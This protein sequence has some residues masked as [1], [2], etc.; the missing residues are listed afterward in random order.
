MQGCGYSTAAARPAASTWPARVPDR[1]TPRPCRHRPVRDSHRL[2]PARRAPRRTCRRCRSRT[3]RPQV[4]GAAQH[5]GGWVPLVLPP[6]LLAGLRPG[7]L[8][9]LHRRLGPDRAQHAEQLPRLAAAVRPARW[10]PGAHRG[11]DRAPGDDRSGHP[12]TGQHARLRRLAVRVHHLQRA[13]RCLD[14]A[15]RPWRLRASPRPTTRPTARRRRPSSPRFSAGVHH[16]QPTRP[17]SSSRSTTPATSSRCRRCRCS[18]APNTDPVVGAA[19]DIACDPNQIAF[20]DGQGTDTDCR[21]IAHR[22]PARGRRRGA[23]ARRQPVRL[24]RHA[25]LRRSPTTRRGAQLKSIT[26]PVPGD[27]DYAT[28][29]GTDCP[30]VAGA[31][32]YQYFGA[33]AGDPSKGYYSYNLGQWHVVALNTAP[34][35]NDADLLRRRLG[36][37]PVAQAGPRGEHV[38]LH[39]RLLP[40]P[41][42][43]LDR[44]RRRRRPISRSGRTSTTA[45]S[46]WCSTVTRTGTSGSRR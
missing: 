40:E 16:Q 20:N 45:A 2:R 44:R 12:G 5:G 36:A 25:G 13:R 3:C 31:G 10:R 34:C 18:V 26:H 6:G 39:A 23:A 15:T 33:A 17:S 30:T 29:G 32:Y 41:A 4:N 42:V 46:T 38:V 28:S 11:G 21:A 7:Q 37:G 43:R 24:R 35:G 22:R 1:S 27:E 8:R 19:G 9:V 14:D